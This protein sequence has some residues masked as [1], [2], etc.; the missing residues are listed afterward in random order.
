MTIATIP[1]GYFEV[2]DR[3]LSN[4]GVVQIN[5]MDCPIVGD[6]SMNITTVDVSHI[7]TIPLN[8]RVVVM[9][10]NPTYKN[11]TE[12]NARMIGEIPYVLLT[13]IPQHLRRT[14]E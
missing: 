10:D 13:R 2:L 1:V 11:S 4:R 12:N 9:S 3:R 6:I 7:S 14:I 8:D 5:N